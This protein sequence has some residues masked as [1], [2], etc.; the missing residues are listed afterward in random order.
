MWVV[1]MGM[2]MGHGCLVMRGMGMSMSHGCLVM[3]G[4]ESQPG[5]P[6]EHG[7]E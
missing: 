5:C 6:G 2:G 7:H 4:T 1:S 3:R